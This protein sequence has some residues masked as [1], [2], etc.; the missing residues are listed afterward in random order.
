M[1]FAL[2]LYVLSYLLNLNVIISIKNNFDQ[3]I[4]KTISSISNMFESVKNYSLVFYKTKFL[5]LS[6]YSQIFIKVIIGVLSA[7]TFYYVGGVDFTI[8]IVKK[9]LIEMNII[10]GPGPYF[11]LKPRDFPPS[12]VA[13][14]MVDAYTLKK[15]HLEDFVKRQPLDA[16]FYEDS[17]LRWY[18][19]EKQRMSD[20]E[21]KRLFEKDYN[22]N[23]NKTV[24][25]LAV[26]TGM[27]VVGVVKS[28]YKNP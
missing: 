16:L 8:L 2:L 26:V 9:L 13:R 23:L 12:C 14:H 7:Y 22:K 11:R 17:W 5:T 21:F 20:A 24:T 18:A 25:G 3:Y 1:I 15:L 10:Q 27:I 6:I 28:Y 19:V 4:I